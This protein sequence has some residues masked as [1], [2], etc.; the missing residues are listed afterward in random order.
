MSS[1]PMRTPR[2]PLP[3]RRRS[4]SLPTTLRRRSS[5]RRRGL[6][7]RSPPGLCAARPA[8][9][10]RDSRWRPARGPA[11]DGRGSQAR[12]SKLRARSGASGRRSARPCRRRSQRRE[13]GVGRDRGRLARRVAPARGGRP[14][15][16][17]G[18]GG[19]GHLRKR[20]DRMEPEPAGRGVRLSAPAHPSWVAGVAR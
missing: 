16:R 11:R 18:R 13:P 4:A 20:L 15:A 1:S 2:A 8:Q 5:S 3:R 10:A 6:R 17:G 12:L 14:R 9:A 19:S 7:P